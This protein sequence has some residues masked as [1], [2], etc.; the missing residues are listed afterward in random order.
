MRVG[1]DRRT[2][3]SVVK[4]AFVRVK[5]FVHRR[6]NCSTVVQF[7]TVDAY[8]TPLLTFKNIF[9]HTLLGS[10]ANKYVVRLLMNAFFRELF[11]K[12]IF[13]TST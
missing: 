10:K 4:N 7:R 13:S 2:A 8:I 11:F 9:K 12:F 3:G 6:A 5:H 1:W